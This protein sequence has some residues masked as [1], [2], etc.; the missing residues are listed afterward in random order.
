M[1][2]QIS[3]SP[4]KTLIDQIVRDAEKET[5]NPEQ[6]IHDFIEKN[7]EK[8]AKKVGFLT[9][10]LARHVI[11]QVKENPDLLKTIAP[12]E[13]ETVMARTGYLPP[14]A[15]KAMVRSA[16]LGTA[17]PPL[18]TR[19]EMVLGE[20]K[21]VLSNFKVSFITPLEV[22]QAVDP[23]EGYNIKMLTAVLNQIT[24]KMINVELEKLGADFAIQNLDIK[25]KAISRGV[26][27]SRYLELNLN[28]PRLLLQT[29]TRLQTLLNQVTQTEDDSLIPSQA[30]LISLVDEAIRESAGTA[31]LPIIS[32]RAN[33]A[34]FRRISLLAY[35]EELPQD[36]DK[37]KGQT[38]PVLTYSFRG[39]AK[40]QEGVAYVD[41]W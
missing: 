31:N 38:T 2:E 29:L 6:I 19:E 33:Y 14:A 18:R 5:R 10:H 13:K 3:P 16:V 1:Q 11:R 34:Q 20:E 25:M 39:D 27:G 8:I 26:G 36:S 12:I 40:L 24:A 23:V 7:K 30:K 35:W 37:K 4:E 22:N 32:S 41:Q 28:K 21:K 17:A 15:K 9:D